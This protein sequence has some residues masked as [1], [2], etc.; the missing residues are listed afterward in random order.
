[1]ADASF[2]VLDELLVTQFSSVGAL[3]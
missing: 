2:P 1:L 3:L